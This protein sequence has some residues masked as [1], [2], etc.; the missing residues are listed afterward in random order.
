MNFSIPMTHPL[1]RRRAPG[2][3]LIELLVV[4]AIIAIL[5]AML[6]PALAKAKLKATSAVCL[7]NQKQLALG[8]TMY[9]PDNGDKMVGFNCS[10][11]WEWRIGSTASGVAPV[12]TKPNPP[13][14]T[15]QALATWQYQ[16]GYIEGALYNFAPNAPLIHCPGDQRNANLNNNAYASYSGVT[17]LNGG[18]YVAGSGNSG[19]YG[20]VE[21]LMKGSG[22]NHPSARFLWVE[23]NDNRGDD[24]NSWLLDNA[25]PAWHDSLAVFH[26]NNS[27]LSFAD[28]H[29]ESHK[30]MNGLTISLAKTG[31]SG[32]VNT[33]VAPAN[34]DI[35]YMVA[36][37]ACVAN[38]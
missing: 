31:S 34:Q 11:N 10:Y 27:T 5:A 37:Y 16:E 24:I 26:G 14:L 25:T 8:W 3:T 30:W 2:F 28:G 6:L 15:G 33:P 22:I 29:A 23:E 38:P 1:R 17:G 21:P 18:V 20:P 9:L 19:A 36:G 32:A 35:N 12:L 7:S 4:I 13:G